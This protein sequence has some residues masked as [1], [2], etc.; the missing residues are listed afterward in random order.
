KVCHDNASP[1]YGLT[2]GCKKILINNGLES[3]VLTSEEFCRNKLAEDHRSRTCPG[4]L[5]A[6]TGF[7][8]Q[9][10]HRRRRSSQPS[11]LHGGGAHYSHFPS[12][13]TYPVTLF[14]QFCVKPLSGFS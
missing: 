7:E 13:T 11:L 1:N 5:A 4:P 3:G 9:P 6:P 10:P 14:Y 12:V 8:I 2:S